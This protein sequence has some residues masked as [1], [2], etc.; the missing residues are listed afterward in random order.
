MS[1]KESPRSGFGGAV[2]VDPFNGKCIHGKTEG[3]KESHDFQSPPFT[4]AER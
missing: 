3:C 1:P 4:K 2:F